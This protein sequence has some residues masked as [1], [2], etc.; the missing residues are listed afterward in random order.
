MKELR[1]DYVLGTAKFDLQKCIDTVS[2]RYVAFVTVRIKI[3]CICKI[4]SFVFEIV[5]LH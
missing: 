1:L 3:Y 4:F 5:T 2:L